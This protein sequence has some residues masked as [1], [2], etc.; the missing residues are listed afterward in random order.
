MAHATD[1]RL[2]IGMQRGKSN[3]VD[4]PRIAL[5]AHRFGARP[6][7]NSDRRIWHSP[8]LRALSALR[9]RLV[10]GQTRTGRS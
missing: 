4:A 8:K 1:I 9:E 7:C 5:Y 2:S 10:K 3:T 6:G